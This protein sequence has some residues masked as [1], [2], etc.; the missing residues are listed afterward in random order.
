MA[1]LDVIR[2]FFEE[3]GLAHSRGVVAISGG[4]DS[5]ALAHL[6]LQLQRRDFFTHLVLAHVN[7]QLRG[8][9]SD[10]DE[11]FVIDLAAKWRLPCRTTRIDVAGKASERGDNLEKTARDLRYA[12]LTQV[13]HEEQAAWLATG[14]SADDQAETVLHRLLR[15]SGLQGLTGIAGRRQLDDRADL[16]RPLLKVRR[17][18]LLAH[19][20]AEQQPFC[21]DQTNLDV[22]FTRNRLRRQ[23]LPLLA[24][25]YQP[26][27]VEVLCRLA[28]QAHAVQGE[29]VRQAGELLHRAELPRAGS[30]VILQAAVLE[31]A[32]PHLVCEVFRLIWQRES[33]S[34]NAM[35]HDAWLRL[36]D[37]AHGQATG[38]DFPDSIQAR[39]RDQVVQVG[40]VDR[41]YPS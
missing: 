37:L 36:A 33:W 32:S 20:L 21:Q 10:A 8:P 16:V 29:I 34:M 28:D 7:H 27:I 39:R 40:R 19:L 6:L 17:D 4:P 13:A 14:H 18:E 26:A 5:V 2:A 15:G 35:D 3:A 38:Q 41:S 24:E 1:L 31:A 22:K 30:W 25:Q 9:E 11:A 23:L 12:W